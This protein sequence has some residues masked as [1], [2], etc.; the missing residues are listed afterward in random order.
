MNDAPQPMSDRLQSALLLGCS[1]ALLI[2][3]G[4]L[5]FAPGVEAGS[6]EFTSGTLLKVGMVVGLAWL[7]APQL[8][9]LG[10]QRMRGTGLAVLGVIAVLTAVRPRFGAIAA[11]L[12]VAGFVG[13]ALLGWVRGVVFGAS[14]TSTISR[15]TVKIE[16]N[17]TRR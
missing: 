1:L 17:P 16:K 6:R 14:G 4:V 2:A 3:G 12:A 15:N 10:W 7:A 9:R 8:R 13:L 11:G 5:S